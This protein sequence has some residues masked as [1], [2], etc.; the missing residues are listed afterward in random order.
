MRTGFSMS[1]SS[2]RSYSGPAFLSYGFRPF[3]FLGAL[4]SGLSVL[5]WMPQFY[6]EL[7]L[8]TRFTPV[9]WHIHELYFGFLTAIVTG[10]L[11]TAVPNWTGRMPVSGSPLLLLVVLWLAGRLA[12]TFSVVT[13]WLPAMLIDAGFMLAVALMIAAEIIAGKNWRNLKIL[14]PVLLLV[15]ANVVF[16]LE[17]EFNGGA[18][19]S[20][21]LAAMA[22]IALIM[23]VGGRVIP[24]FT[25]NW[26]ARERPGRLPI[27]FSRF[28][29]VAIAVT[30]V[31]MAGWTVSPDH[32]VTGGGLGVAAVLQF[33]RLARWAGYRTWADP[34]VVVM[35]VSY[36]F[37]PVGLGLIALSVLR[38][39]LLTQV[40]G[41][42]ALSVGAIG[43][44]TLS[45]M[46]RA[47][48]GHT[49]RKLEASAV[50]CVLFASVF[51][52]AVLRIAAGLNFSSYDV[53]LHVA[54]FA[55]LLAF[56]GFGIVFLRPFFTR[57]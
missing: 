22:A 48:L 57:H 50:V 13:G 26:L 21:R 3:F 34:L 41:I 6:G 17:A 15:A 30:L 23:I 51:V 16:H 2:R 25:R 20:R 38:P 1:A 53:L 36:L 11:F 42:H 12:V 40:A 47:S 19:I 18:D 37:I 27:P 9:D 5:L 32:L 28:D 10:F 56:G 43:G 44:M 7:E 55:W 31:A 24:S 29:A 46:V 54:A 33:I 8:S 14:L 35:H 49:G 39:D 52:A 45:I 4:Y